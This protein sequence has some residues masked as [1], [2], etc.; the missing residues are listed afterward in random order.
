MGAP[1]LNPNGDS[2]FDHWEVPIQNWWTQNKGKY[3]V[4]TESDRP[5]IVD[6][7][8]TNSSKPKLSIIEPNTKTIYSPDQKI[9]L[10]ISNSSPYSL[11]KIE[12]F[13]ND[14]YL[15]TYEYPAV[16]SFIP[17]ELENLQT[18]NEL[19]IIAYDSIYNSGET[20]LVFKVQ[21]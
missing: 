20:T 12:V 21:E 2:Q 14:T 4:I 16:F 7:V 9:N 10:K 13:I 15:G 18:D 11:L 17:R 6:D 3:G 1:P 5:T 19:K 8:H